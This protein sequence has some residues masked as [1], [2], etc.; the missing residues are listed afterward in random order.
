MLFGTE[1]LLLSTHNFCV[2]WRNKNNVWILGYSWVML[3]CGQET[4]CCTPIMYTFINFFLENRREILPSFVEETGQLSGEKIS[5]QGRNFLIAWLYFVF[6]K[7]HGML[8]KNLS[9]FLLH[10]LMY[11][12]LGCVML[13]IS[14]YWN[15]SDFTAWHVGCSWYW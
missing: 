1:A 9:W 15:L 14:M 11:F 5:I 10:A 6:G 8:R 4:H 7:Y 12:S 3:I 2:S 13:I